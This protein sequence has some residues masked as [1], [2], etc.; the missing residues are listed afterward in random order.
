MEALSS[1]T[2][3]NSNTATGNRA[4]FVNTTGNYNIAFGDHAL[5]VNSTGSNNTASGYSSLYS[6]STGNN[7]TATGISALY[8]NTTGHANTAG[9]FYSLFFNA[10]GLNN[11][12]FGAYSLYATT[13]SQYNTAIG[14]NAGGIRNMGWNNTLVGANAD[15]NAND[16]YNCVAIGKDVICTANNQARIGNS[17]TTSIGGYA[18]WSNISDGRI[19]KNIMDN[20]PGLAFISKLKPVTYN[21]DL[22]AADKIIQKPSAKHKDGKIIPVAQF[23]MDARKQKEKIVYTGF[24]AQD[25]EKAAKEIGFDF[26][27]VDA[28]KNDKDLY[29]LR[30]AEFVV[31]LVKAVQEQQ[32]QMDDMKKEIDLLKE[33]NKILIQL[34]NKKN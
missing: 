15:L 1:N 10:G 16:V 3:G 19:K 5:F 13:N 34:L 4:L 32:E 6:N 30:Y 26:S 21:L 9:G 8:S 29:G 27:G 23:E 7:N 20:V 18:N 11:T 12:A 33:Q 17:S 25:V 14:F 22:N 31:P 28:P 2:V 24:I